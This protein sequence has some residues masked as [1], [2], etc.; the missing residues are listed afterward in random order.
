MS[1]IDTLI[2][3]RTQ[4]D[5]ANDTDKAYISYMDLNRIEETVK[6]LSDILNKYGYRNTTKNKINW[7]MS[8]LRKQEDCERIKSNYEVL[9]KVYAY[10]FITPSFEWMSIEEANNIERILKDISVF[11]N[12]MIYSFKYVG[13]FNAGESEGLI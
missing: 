11:I 13:T 6:Y 12:K 7:T 9:Q 5:I 10:K 1:I 2:Y 4:A 3:D 8:E